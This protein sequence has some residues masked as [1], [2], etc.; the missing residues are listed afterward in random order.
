MDFSGLLKELQP[1]NITQ[2]IDQINQV[3]DTQWRE[4]KLRQQKFEVHYQTESLL[5][6]FCD[7]DNWPTIK[8]TDDPL[9]QVYKDD[10]E[11]IIK[12]VIDNHYEPGGKVI[13]AVFAKL[14]P[15]GI[16]KPHVDTHPSFA[17]G[18]RVHVP[19][20]TNDRVRFTIGGRPHHLEV[21]TIYEVNNLKQHS[22][23]NKGK[24]PRV[25]LIFDYVPPSKMSDIEIMQTN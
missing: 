7:L 5:L 3:T 10:V 16:I 8:V 11:P 25:T 17:I 15:N 4:N 20:T 19:I 6:K 24:T 18:H 23:M 21:G 9:W 22:V 12:Q 14:N 2:L 1:I 13:R